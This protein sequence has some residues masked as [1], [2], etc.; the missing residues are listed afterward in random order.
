MFV[1]VGEEKEE[2]IQ[3]EVISVERSA[4]L[5]SCP[6]IR[7]LNATGRIAAKPRPPYQVLFRPNDREVD[8]VQ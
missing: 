8:Y 5:V 7:A 3:H 1:P 2:T 4:N 6:F